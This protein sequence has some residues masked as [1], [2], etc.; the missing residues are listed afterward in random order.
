MIIDH[1]KYAAMYRGLHP[2][3]AA[4]FDF[5]ARADLAALPDGR[6][7]IAGDDVY[8]MLSAYRTKPKAEGKWEAHRR[9]M[10]IQCLLSGRE[11]VGY[12]CLDALTVSKEYD[13]AADYLLFEGQGDTVTLQPGVFALFG[14]Q[15][16]HQPGL[17]LGRPA[18]VRKVVVKIRI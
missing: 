11:S 8:A 3:L 10:D 13:V 12:A 1:L 16:A 14:P 6:Q 2:R 17:T 18:D 4:A 5:L 15:D 7:D 9:Y